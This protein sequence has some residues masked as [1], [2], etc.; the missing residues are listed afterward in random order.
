MKFSIRWLS[1]CLVASSCSPPV[2]LPQDTPHSA[3]EVTVAPSLDDSDLVAKICQLGPPNAQMEGSANPLVQ[4]ASQALAVPDDLSFTVSLS[5]RDQTFEI[6]LGAGE[7][8]DLIVEQRGT[9]LELS[10]YHETL[11]LIREVDSL[12]AGQGVEPL[13]LVADVDTRYELQIRPLGAVHRAE[14]R[15]LL[16]TNRHPA[17]SEDRHRAAA[18]HRFWQAKKAL[19][20]RRFGAAVGSIQEA[21]SSFQSVTDDR[22]RIADAAYLEAIIQL[23]ASRATLAQEALERALK[24]YGETSRSTLH[25]DTLNTLGHVLRLQG[26]TGEA[27]ARLHHALVLQKRLGQRGGEAVALNN[28]GQC[29]A[30]SEDYAAALDFYH[31]A[32][33]T[34]LELGDPLSHA[35]TSGNSGDLRLA[36]ADP[37]GARAIYC[38]GLGSLRRFGARSQIAES[39]EASLLAGLGIALF[40]SGETDH[41]PSL[42]RHAESAFHRLGRHSLRAIAQHN[43]AWLALGEKSY[44]EAWLGFEEAMRLF[45]EI[46]DR[47]GQASAT[48][49]LGYIELL[50]SPEPAAATKAL[51]AFQQARQLAD[52]AEKS[53]LRT[54]IEA[55][56][57][58]AFERLGRLEEGISHNSV[59]LELL[60]EQ[61]TKPPT[62]LLQAE[63]LADHYRIFETQI[64]LLMQAADRAD[65][66]E[67]VQLWRQALTV[68]E[69][70]RSRS[71]LDGLARQR[72]DLRH[73][74]DPQ[75]QHSLQ[76]SEQTLNRLE[77]RRHALSQEIA[78]SDGAKTERWIQELLATESHLRRARV[79]HSQAQALLALHNPLMQHDTA[80]SRRQIDALRRNLPASTVMLVY[81]LGKEHSV[82]WKVTAEDLSAFRLPPAGQ[83][84]RLVQQLRR[85]LPQ[86]H[87]TVRPW[88]TPAASKLSESLL[89]PVA[90]EIGRRR[91]WIVADGSLHYLPLEVLPDPAAEES[92][93]PLG[94]IH[95]IAYLPSLGVMQQ[96]RRRC[97]ASGAPSSI[98]VLADPI[99]SDDPRAPVGVPAGAAARGPIEAHGKPA[100]ESLRLGL[101]R[102]RFSEH[103]AQAIATAAGSI[104]T[105]IATGAE[106]SRALV[107]SGEMAAYPILHFATHGFADVDS[108]LGSSLALSMF[109]AQGRI[110]EPSL[111]P[112]R[113]IYNL[114][115]PAQLVVLS[116]CSTGLGRKIRGEGLVGLPHGFFSAGAAQVVVSSWVIDDAATADLMTSFYDAMLRDGLPPAAA[117]LVARQ[118]AWHQKDSTHAS[119]QHWGAFRLLGDCSAIKN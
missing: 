25:A 118:K 73:G 51:A 78:W 28:L 34:Y 1:V 66:A 106:A 89:G 115:L 20:N 100:G 105:R 36:M 119:P 24:L 71:L 96:L 49:H 12:E 114:D 74:V 48:L 38:A 35:R 27:K 6:A 30:Q 101:G 18:E 64:R 22:G 97:A 42:L 45:A 85:D 55:G 62:P 33:S 108:A 4:P 88:P 112:V 103:E 60:E 17:T 47:S 75:L 19:R 14:N 7:A 57:A 54:E 3:Q 11:G 59:A 81:F 87:G 46:G 99:Y 90:Q 67:K 83:I 50:S 37:D 40:R 29:Y 8:L 63:V 15:P 52:S 41:A 70:A 80:D 117:L 58:L 104:P 10:L 32:E 68:S 31:R 76:E 82:L 72:V 2:E 116:A 91:L 56:L 95:E 98:A 94:T 23:Q 110:L 107:L 26:K 61:R 5:G 111:L 9:D 16:T 53:A 21:Q 77:E 84:D 13:P 92:P 65:R 69:T 109:D 113:D 39:I 79:D 43:L 93:Q 44:E 102:L 86:L